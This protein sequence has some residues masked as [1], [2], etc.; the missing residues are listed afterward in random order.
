MLKRFGG[1]GEIRTHDLF[2]AMEARS[3]L[4]HRPKPGDVFNISRRSVNM[5]AMDRKDAWDL[6]CEFTKS[7]G[8]RRHALAVETCVVAYA[9][10]FGDGE[11]NRKALGRSD[12]LAASIRIPEIVVPA[13]DI[14]RA[15]HYSEEQQSV[16]DKRVK[17]K[18]FAAASTRSAAGT[19][20]AV[21]WRSGGLR[22]LFR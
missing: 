1:P 12:A 7:D 18:H 8:L 16:V 4:R 22:R 21:S 2:H 9:R 6:L 17:V 20:R 11:N 10:K 5:V 19:A 15:R 13:V 14:D 3:Q